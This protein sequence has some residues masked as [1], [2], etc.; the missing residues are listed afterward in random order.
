M[1]GS[2]RKLGP[3]P[4]ALSGRQCRDENKWAALRQPCGVPSATIVVGAGWIA[5]VGPVGGRR[6]ADASAVALISP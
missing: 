6:H 4:P 2:A 5:P 3:G 1:R